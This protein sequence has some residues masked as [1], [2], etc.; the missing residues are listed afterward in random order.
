MPP[1]II[2]VDQLS[3]FVGQELGTSSWHLVTQEEVNQF[4][5]ATHDTYW[6]HTDPERA[7]KE[8][9]FKTTIAHG[10]YTLS[11]C[12]HMIQQVLKVEGAKITVNYGA[13]R[14]RYPAPVPVGSQ[15]RGRVTLSKVEKVEGGLQVTVTVTIEREGEA[16][17]AC[18]AELLTRHF[19]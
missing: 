1:R 17:P 16:K 3:Q 14:V 10:F 12:A 7:R 4:A 15:I 5:E 18:V 9:P 8:S 2:P 19:L 13:N 6:I 11:L